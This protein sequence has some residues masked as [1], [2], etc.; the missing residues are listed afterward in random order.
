MNLE[1]AITAD[2]LTQLATAKRITRAR[3]ITPLVDDEVGAALCIFDTLPAGAKYQL[4]SRAID[5]TLGPVTLGD[6][7]DA[8]GI[9]DPA[10]LPI[11]TAGELLPA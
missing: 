5:S 10:T 11:P 8:A 9:E 1:R 3:G 6:I 7:L 2:Q 4:L